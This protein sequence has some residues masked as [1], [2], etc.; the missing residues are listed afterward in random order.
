MMNKMKWILILLGI[1][2]FLV[3]V[4][5]ISYR[6]GSSTSIKETD[7]LIKQKD[8]EIKQ[9]EE[10]LKFYEKEIQDRDMKI[11][12]LRRQRQGIKKPVSDE[13]L[14]NRFKVLGYDISIYYK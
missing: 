13:E 11:A 14:I 2:L 10:Q 5:S 8:T 6:L 9:L 3:L 7:K 12:S 4:S 1:I